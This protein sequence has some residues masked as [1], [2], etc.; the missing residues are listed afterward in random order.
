MT[1]KNLNSKVLK[2]NKGQDIKFKA[3]EKEVEVHKMDQKAKK[4]NQAVTNEELEKIMPMMAG[5]KIT[6]EENEWA[7]ALMQRE[8]N[9]G[10]VIQAQAIMTAPM[11]QELL[12]DLYV[13]LDN[14]DVFKRALKRLGATDDMFKEIS[15]EIVKERDDARAKA[16]E[17]AKKVKKEQEDIKKNK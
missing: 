17:L 7:K 13:M 15:E 10:A 12:G 16:S 6:K 4:E 9:L 1:K 14:Q 11:K 3:E 2:A 5:K 8:V